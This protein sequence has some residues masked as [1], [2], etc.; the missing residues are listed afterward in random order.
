MYSIA[1]HYV[2]NLHISIQLLLSPNFKPSPLIVINAYFVAS[3]RLLQG[4]KGGELVC[5]ASSKTSS[6]EMCA[7]HC[8]QTLKNFFQKIHDSRITLSAL[9]H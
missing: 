1:E 8:K 5:I 2:N 9:K 4:V 6:K 7:F 3:Y